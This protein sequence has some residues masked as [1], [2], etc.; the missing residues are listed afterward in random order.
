MFRMA[1]A[2]L[3]TWESGWTGDS[4]SENF[5]ERKFPWVVLTLFTKQVEEE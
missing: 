3:S 2:A 5:S 1:L 4:G